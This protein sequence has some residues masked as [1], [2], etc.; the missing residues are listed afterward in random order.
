MLLEKASIKDL[1]VVSDM[2]GTLLTS[3]MRLLGCN[4]ETIRLFRALGGHFTVATGRVHSSVQMYP[5]LVEVIDPAITC[6]GCVLYD[7]QKNVAAKSTVLQRVVARRAVRD[8]LERFPAVGIMVMADDMRNYR[9]SPS[10]MIEKLA[11]EEKMAYFIRPDEDYPEEWNKVL[12]AGPP[13][14]LVQVA[15]YVKNRTYPGVYFVHTSPTYFEM[16]PK[17]VSKASALH[18]LCGL[19]GIQM[20]H[21]IMIGDYLNDLDIMKQAGHAVAMGNAPVEVQMAADEVIATNDQGGVGQ[22]LYALIKRY[23]E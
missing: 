9:M 21:T 23:T 12:F 8:I 10:R 16:M 19:L 4:L 18:E 17:G 2:D 5:D 15:D 11:D 7:F 1:L 22:F 13:E 6:G 3:D 14:L 20:K